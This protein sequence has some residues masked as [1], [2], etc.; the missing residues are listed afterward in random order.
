[1]PNKIQIKRG[2][3][4]DIPILDSGEFGFT[5]DSEEVY[6]GTGSSNIRILTSDDIYTNSNVDSHLSGSNGI[7]YSEGVIS[8]TYGSAS[9]T[10]CQGNDSRLSDARTPTSHDNTYHSTNYAAASLTLTASTGLTGG[11]DLTTNRSFSVSYGTTSGTACQG[12]D[13]RLGDARTP[14]S[15]THGNL[16]NDGKIGSTT[17]LLIETTT[18]GVLTTKSA[19]T[20]YQF[21]R[22]DNTWSDIID[23]G[24]IT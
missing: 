22:G 8:P 13:S 2:N 23:G 7:N 20:S 24:E 16:T 12:N 1:M 21:L 15:H 17:N 14:T 5:I 3:I 18:S 19:G 10:I 9:N 4:A 6:I 11:G